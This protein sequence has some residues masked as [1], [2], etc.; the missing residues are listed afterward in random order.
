MTRRNKSERESLI[1]EQAV[2]TRSYSVYANPRTKNRP[3]GLRPSMLI[4]QCWIQVRYSYSGAIDCR[5]TLPTGLSPAWVAD[6]LKSLI[7]A[8][9]GLNELGAVYLHREPVDFRKS[10][11]W[12]RGDCG[13]SDGAVALSGGG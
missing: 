7:W 4:Q 11:Q 8:V 1:A 10:D 2:S 12:S 9:K 6:L 13:K 3:V 5:L